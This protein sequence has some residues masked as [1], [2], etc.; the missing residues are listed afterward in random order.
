MFNIGAQ[1]LLVILAIALIVVG[2][3]KLPDL[4]RS[5]GK[6]LREFRKVQDDVKDMVRF[7]LDPT[8]DRPVSRG[9]VRPTKPKVGGGP[10]TVAS[11]GPPATN[12]TSEAPTSDYPD[13]TSSAPDDG[14]S[15]A[16][17]A[18]AGRTADPT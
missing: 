11:D 4:A 12:G 15:G 17:D 8:S 16:D 7:D 10:G 18:A 6:G 2:P 9:P 14:A 1:E 3:A 5:L 13:A